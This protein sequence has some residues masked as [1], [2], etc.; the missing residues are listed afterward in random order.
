VAGD[1]GISSNYL[2]AAPC[3]AAGLYLL[4]WLPL[5]GSGPGLPRPATR[6]PWTA[7]RLGL[8]LGLIFGLA[9]GHCAFAWIAPLLGVAGMQATE[10]L[11]LP[12]VLLT[13]FAVGHLAVVLLAAS[14]L[15]L[16]QRWLDALGRHRGLPLGRAACG[17]LL[18]VAAGALI[19]AV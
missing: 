16:V 13:L 7:L 17:V 11:A 19:V 4:A 12:A 3:L 2:V 18:L 14:S 10:G 5:P 8:G 9:L 6:G 15:A 1:Q